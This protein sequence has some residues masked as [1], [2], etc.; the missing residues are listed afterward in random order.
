VRRLQSLPATD[1]HRAVI[2]IPKRRPKNIRYHDA[3]TRLRDYPGVIRQVAVTGWGRENPTLGLSNN[4]DVTA[5][6]VVSRYVG[7]N[8]VEDTLGISVNFF[9]TLATTRAEPSP[10][11]P[12]EFRQVRRV[13]AILREGGSIH[14]PCRCLRKALK[15]T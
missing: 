14:L 5:R 8:G 11:T 10:T 12:V 4:L 15:Q 6:P 13:L 9:W 2:D 1:G 7:R 3:T